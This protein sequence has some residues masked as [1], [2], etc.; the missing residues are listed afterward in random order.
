MG[1]RR[2]DRLRAHRDPAN[3]RTGLIRFVRSIIADRAAVSATPQEFD[4]VLQCVSS[5]GG[6]AEDYR[7]LYLEGARNLIRAFPNRHTSFHEQHERL[8]AEGWERR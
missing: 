4:V 5:R 8:R 2:L 7:R 6:D 3:W 1:G